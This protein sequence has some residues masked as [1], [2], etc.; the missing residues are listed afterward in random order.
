MTKKTYQFTVTF[1]EENGVI[2]ATAPSLSGCVS[3]GHT[4]KE[5]EK[6]I[7][8]AIECHVESMLEDGD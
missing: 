2:I 7:R 6:N 8:E 3:F 1:K 5:A 4:L